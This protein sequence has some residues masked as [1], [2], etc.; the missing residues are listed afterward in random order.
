M[1][2]VT[3]AFDVAIA[4]YQEELWIHFARPLSIEIIKD[5]RSLE[6]NGGIRVREADEMFPAFHVEFSP[7]HD[8]VA[9]ADSIQAHLEAEHGLTVKVEE[10]SEDSGETYLVTVD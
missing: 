5:I 3:P 2:K 6:E 10:G 8:A 7:V 1:I 9:I 4:Y